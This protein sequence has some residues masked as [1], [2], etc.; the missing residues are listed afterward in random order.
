MNDYDIEL[1][2]LLDKAIEGLSKEARQGIEISNS[3]P[4][5]NVTEFVISVNSKETGNANTE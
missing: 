2:E 3:F 5:N 4:Q 1:K